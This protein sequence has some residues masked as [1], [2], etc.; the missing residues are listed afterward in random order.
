MIVSI[1]DDATAPL[2]RLL[3]LPSAEYDA[4]KKEIDLIQNPTTPEKSE[5]PGAD[6]SQ[7]A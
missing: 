5:L 4:V 2:D 7:T 1:D 3:D 6:I